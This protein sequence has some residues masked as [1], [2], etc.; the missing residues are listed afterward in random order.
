MTT[1][2][3]YLI[4]GHLVGDFL[5]QPSRLIA[6][7]Q[8]KP[9]YFLSWLSFSGTQQQR[10]FLCLRWLSAFEPD[11]RQSSKGRL[12]IDGLDHSCVSSFISMHTS[13][14]GSMSYLGWARRDSANSSGGMA[15]NLTRNHHQ[16]NRIK[17]PYLKIRTGR[18]RD[19]SY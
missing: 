4:I 19:L 14:T 16:E 6:W 15:T 12:Q 17:R 9:S 7:S 1:I 13:P 18:A 5:L 2:L 8:Q 3:S 10:L 11:S